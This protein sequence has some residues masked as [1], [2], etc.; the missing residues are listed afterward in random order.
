MRVTQGPSVRS[1]ARLRGDNDSTVP[2]L[3]RYDPHELVTGPALPHLLQRRVGWKRTVISTNMV[4]QLLNDALARA[5]LIDHAGQPLRYTPHDFRR[6]FAAEAVTGGLP[7]QIAA[8]LL[9]HASIATTETYLAVFQ[10]DLIRSYRTFLDKRRG[11]RPAEEY[12]E[13]TDEEWREFQQH[14]HAGKLELGDCA[15]PYGTPCQHEHLCLRCPMLRVSPRQRDRLIEIIH[16]LTGRIAEAR[17]NGWLGEVQGLQTSL[18]KAQ[19]KLAGLDRSIARGRSVGG[20]VNLG[21]PTITG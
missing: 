7:V 6:V 9:G 8:R 5:A 2:L 20:P 1:A 3:A 19:E 11:V 15:R 16:N 18:T 13:P 21:M 4:Y 17:I 10:E 14:F 12:R